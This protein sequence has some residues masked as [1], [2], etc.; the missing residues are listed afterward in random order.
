MTEVLRPPLHT[1]G[2]ALVDR[3]GQPVRLR[4]VN[5][6]GAESPDFVVGGLHCQPL[7]AIVRRIVELGA[8]A[9]RLPFSTHLVVENPVVRPEAV[10]ANPA[11]IGQPA[12]AILDATIAALTAAGLAVVLDNHTTHPDWCCAEGDGNDL[13]HSRASPEARWIAVWAQLARRYR[14]NPLVIAADLRNEPR[15]P[16]RWTTATPA[17]NWRAAAER[18]GAAILEEHPDWLVIVE[19]IDYASDLRGAGADPVQLPRPG[20]LVYSVHDYPWFHRRN[21]STEAMRQRWEQR[22][23]F[24]R[25]ASVLVGEFGLDVA[26]WSQ[27]SERMPARWLQALIGYLDERG[28]SWFYWPLNGTMSSAAPRHGRQFG[29]REP[30]G[31]L[32]ER[33]DGPANDRLARWLFAPSGSSAR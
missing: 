22:W 25:K 11:L 10:A 8:N 12:L 32:S 3:D 9:V 15:G 18:A 24:L 29:A 20:R 16:A 19:G 4:G 14:A 33:W 17:A 31:L 30:F 1:V 28:G 13:W 2:V 6:Y 26:E 23:G 21:A 27:P 7:E 5:W